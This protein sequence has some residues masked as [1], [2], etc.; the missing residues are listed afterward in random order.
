MYMAESDV[1]TS[2][3]SLRAQVTILVAELAHNT[4][5]VVIP[6]TVTQYLNERSLFGKVCDSLLLGNT[7]DQAEGNNMCEIIC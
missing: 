5:L 2:E 7:T 6:L 3:D 4:T 1:R